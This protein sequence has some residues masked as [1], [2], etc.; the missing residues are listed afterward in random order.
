MPVRQQLHAALVGG[1]REMR[2]GDRQR[3][4]RGVPAEVQVDGRSAFE[5]RLKIAPESAFQLEVCGNA[6]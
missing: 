2:V 1:V 3:D 5:R 4:R 6:R